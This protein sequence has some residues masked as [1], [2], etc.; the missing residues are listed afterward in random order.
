MGALSDAQETSHDIDDSVTVHNINNAKATVKWPTHLTASVEE[1]S[2]GKE[3]VHDI[4][5]TAPTVTSGQYPGHC[6]LGYRYH[7]EDGRL[8]GYKVC[9]CMRVYSRV[10][11]CAR[12]PFIVQL[13]IDLLPKKQHNYFQS[14]GICWVIEVTGVKRSLLLCVRDNERTNHLPLL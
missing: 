4:P 7:P 9:V 13:G 12:S 5:T 14:S 1:L 3:T 10:C 2:T 8:Q 11:G 6:A